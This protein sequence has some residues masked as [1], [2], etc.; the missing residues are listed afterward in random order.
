MNYYQAREILDEK[1]NEGTG[2]FHFT[3]QNGKAIYAVGY[4]AQGCPGHDSKQEA[5]ACFNKYQVD[6]ATFHTIPPE[7]AH[8][9][10]RCEVCGKHT[11]SFAQMAYGGSTHILCDEHLNKEGLAQAMGSP[12][13][14]DTQIISSY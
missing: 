8:S 1:T 14:G 2:K 6:T 11:A 4:C 12:T 5:D 7:K 9:L 10:H 13:E 3:C